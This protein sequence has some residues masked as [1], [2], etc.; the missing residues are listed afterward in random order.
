[1]ISEYTGLKNNYAS[2]ASSLKHAAHQFVLQGSLTDVPQ[3]QNVARLGVH[4]FPRLRM[5][6]ILG[7]AAQ[8]FPPALDSNAQHRQHG[9]TTA[10]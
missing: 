10:H 7:L 9:E 4:R 6:F 8:S 1:M 2:W 3:L 5:F